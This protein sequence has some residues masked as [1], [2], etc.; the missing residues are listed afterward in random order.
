[1]TA[2]RWRQ[3]INCAGP[4]VSFVLTEKTAASCRSF[5]VRSQQSAQASVLTHEPPICHL[6]DNDVSICFSFLV[7][8]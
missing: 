1:M 8:P 4:L 5:V 6:I 3:L 2:G 7:A